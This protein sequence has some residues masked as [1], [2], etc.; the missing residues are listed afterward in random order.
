MVRRLAVGWR[1]LG[2][3]AVPVLVFQQAGCTV[4]PDIF[5]QSVLLGLTDA[6]AFA[7]DNVVVAFR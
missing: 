3:A 2:G 1:L 7:L 4:G 5:R 6:L